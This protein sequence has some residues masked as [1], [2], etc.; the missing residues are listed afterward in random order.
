MTDSLKWEVCL[1][2]VLI[3]ALMA[4]GVCGAVESERGLALREN[5]LLLKWPE[6]ISGQLGEKYFGMSETRL[7][8]WEH[9]SAGPVSFAAAV[10]SRAG[11]MSSKMSASGGFGS[12]GSLLGE[13]K[14]LERWDM[15]FDH[16]DEDGASLSSRIDRLNARFSIG[17]FDVNIGRQPFSMGTSHFVGVLDVVA[18][19]A[20]GA[21]DASYKPGVDA[22]RIGRGFG[23]TSEAEILYVA[24]KDADDS[25]IIGRYRTSLGSVDMELAGGQFR[26]RVFG[27]IG[28]EGGVSPFGYW[29]ELAFFERIAAGEKNRGGWSEAAVSAVLGLD[30]YIEADFVLGAAYMHQ[31]FGARD[32][33]ELSDVYNDAPF[34]EGWAF[35]G[36][37]DY[38]L[39]TLSKE[40][41]PLVQANVAGILNLID[42]STLWQP[43]ITISTGD[44]TDLSVYGWFG[45]GESTDPESRCPRV[46]SEFGDMP[47]GVG[48]FARWFF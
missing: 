42:S 39:V 6:S 30:Y 37:A 13:S 18:P 25:A 44:N 34:R 40:L 15:T 9:L 3:M 22:V 38:G 28:W 36:A 48:M 41:H 20:P 21:L 1:L 14:P 16:V 45:S 7:R 43:Q 35:L 4:A 46:E 17:A 8:Y 10:D 33:G 5:V 23:M 29:G 31:D 12:E 26:E 11:F 24:S 47:G 27:G 19:F 32:V 2:S